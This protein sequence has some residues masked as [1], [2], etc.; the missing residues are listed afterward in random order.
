MK[1]ATLS[2]CL[3]CVSTAVAGTP[4]VWSGYDVVFS[5]AAFADQNDPANQDRLTPNVWFTRAV[6]Q[7]IYNAAQEE[8][9]QGV[10]GSGPSPVDTEWAFG[11]TADLGSLTF[12]TW[13]GAHSGNPPGLIGQNMVVHLISDDIYVDIRL[14]SW[15]VGPGSGGSFSWVRG[16]GVFCPGDAN[17]DALVNF[18]DLNVVLENWGSAG[19]AG[20]LDADGDV[21]FD[22]LNLLL[23]NWAVSCLPS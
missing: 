23:E 3:T 19:P 5:K 7:G 17:G 20:D 13:A 16:E 15:G 11:T 18:D 12:T 2:L 1:Y 4:A 6:V 14:T 10:G 22:D 9:Y 8:G 21:D